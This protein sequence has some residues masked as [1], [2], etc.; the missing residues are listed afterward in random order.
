MSKSPKS[1]KARHAK[2]KKRITEIYGLTGPRTKEEHREI[3]RELEKLQA[4]LP[5]AELVS[6]HRELAIREPGA[7]SPV[8]RLLLDHADSLILEWDALKK[9]KSWGKRK[10]IKRNAIGLLGDWGVGG[11]VLKL[12]RKCMT[13]PGRPDQLVVEFWGLSEDALIAASIEAIRARHPSNKTPSTLT[14]SKLETLINKE[15]D[16][17][18]RARIRA[19]KREIKILPSLIKTTPGD[20]LKAK[21]W[22]VED[23]LKAEIKRLEAMLTEKV[24]TDS[25]WKVSKNRLPKKPFRKKILR[26]WTDGNYWAKVI[27]LRE[28]LS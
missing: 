14:E 20:Q 4:K 13:D 10:E 8:R 9:K 25:A 21:V 2:I 16:Q 22:D 17:R 26:W 11:S 12:A 3:A 5:Q 15:L 23:N 7:S 24:V 28:E 6:L 1:P 18:H 27:Q 19:L